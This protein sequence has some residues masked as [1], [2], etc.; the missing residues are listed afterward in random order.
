[1]LDCF[2]LIFQKDGLIMSFAVDEFI[3][4]DPYFRELLLDIK[5][6]GSLS[7]VIIASLTIGLAVARSIASDILTQRGQEEG[8]RPLCPKCGRLLESKGILPRS[9]I[10]IIGTIYWKRRGWRCTKKCKIG[11]ITPSDNELGLQSNQRVSNELKQVAC[12]LAV[13]VP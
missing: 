6:K 2:L 5:K 1:M 13:F 8:V 11:Q 4:Q 10:I 9:I 7:A 12:A 3:N